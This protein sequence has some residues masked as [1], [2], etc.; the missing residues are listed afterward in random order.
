MAH[1][2]IDQIQP[3]Q[4]IS[5]TFMV[6]QPVLRNT[7]R[8]D[9][10]IAMYL[11]DKTGKANARMWQAT[12]EIYQSIPKE[13]FLHVQA[14]SEL[15]QN[16][17]QLVVNNLTVVDP[18]KV[19][20]SDYMPRTEK[21]IRQMY[22]EVEAILK[23]EI[24]SKDMALIVGAF[25]EDKDLM[26]EFCQAPAAMQMHHPYLGG[27]LEHV[28]NMMRVALAIF[29]FYPKIQ[30][31]IVLAA[32]FLHDIAKTSELSYKMGISYTNEG[33]LLGHLAMGTVLI[34][35]KVQELTDEGHVIDREIL[36]ALLHIM[37][38]HHGRYEFGAAKLPATA[39]AFMVNYIDDLDAKMNQVAMLIDN[40][41]GDTDWTAYQKSLET[42]LFRPRP[43]LEEE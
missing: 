27:L 41:P 8:G 22:E 13:G 16:Q 19:N 26:R 32:I 11:S 4:M 10:Y 23:S 39:E 12:Q 24:K 36:N 5:D 43:L 33:Q 30:K 25:L 21:N 17:L 7:T 15:Y 29:P 1:L 20:H 38:S 6:T 31:D 2:F 35:R 14:K 34:E 18:E 37:I 42:R 9:L 28:H 3:G 40:D